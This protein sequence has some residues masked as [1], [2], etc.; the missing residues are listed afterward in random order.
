MNIAKTLETRLHS[1]SNVAQDLSGRF[2]AHSFLHH[3]RES[4]YSRIARD[5][6]GMHVN[7]ERNCKRVFLQ[8][9]CFLNS[10]PFVYRFETGDHC[11]LKM[12]VEKSCYGITF[13]QSR[14][15]SLCR[16]IFGTQSFGIVALESSS[17]TAILSFIQFCLQNQETFTRIEVH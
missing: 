14:Y 13:K 8:L 5:R 6:C 1:A 10:D 3:G 9:F 11:M 2:T 15:F 17:R 4:G 16:Y 12:Q 7:S